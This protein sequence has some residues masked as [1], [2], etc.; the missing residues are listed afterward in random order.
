MQ[1]DF[2]K[3][4]IFFH[5]IKIRQDQSLFLSASR[6]VNPVFINVCQYTQKHTQ[7]TVA[8]PHG[9]FLENSYMILSPGLELLYYEDILKCDIDSKYRKSNYCEIIIKWR[10]IMKHFHYHASPTIIL[11]RTAIIL[12]TLYLLSSLINFSGFLHALFYNCM[13]IPY[14]LCF[15]SCWSWKMGII[16][17]SWREKTK[18]MEP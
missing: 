18:T 2:N 6:N 7:F 9:F 16:K 10:W 17:N 4:I 14:H 11:L 15:L 1:R 13:P 3:N 8:F 12:N 5:L